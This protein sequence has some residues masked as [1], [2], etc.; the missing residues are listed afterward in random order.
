M[1]TSTYQTFLMDSEE[2]TSW[3]KLLD[4]KDYPDLG[5]A[6]EKLDITTLSQ[7]MR[8]Y[9]L[10]IQDTGNMEFT[11]NYDLT[12]YKKL[13]KLEGKTRHYA[14][15]FSGTEAGDTVT[16]SGEF[17]KFKFQGQ[18]SVYPVGGGVNEVRDMKVTLA[19]STEIT[20]DESEAV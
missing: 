14:V 16:P 12:E 4:I 18:L 13:K 2:G 3:N 11:C 1:A 10:G 7:R 6:P 9:I 20:L 17:G 19:S 8:A 15:W 5:G